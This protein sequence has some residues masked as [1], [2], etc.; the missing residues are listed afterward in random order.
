MGLSL[1]TLTA[2]QSQ[3]SSSKEEKGLTI[4]TSFYPVYAMTKL[5][6]G[7][8]NTVSMIQSGAG[9]HGFEPSANDVAKIYDADL[10][11]YHSQ[12][13]E[14]WAGDLDPS[15]QGS[16]V[17]VF[18][19]SSALSLEKVPGLEDMEVKAG[20]D[21]S[22]LYDPHTWTDPILV[23]QEAESIAKKLAEADSDHADSYYDNAA[24]LKVEAE[25]LTKTYQD[26]FASL[27]NKVFVTQHTAFSYLARRFGLEQ[28]GIAGVSSEQ[29]PT[30][31]Q[32]AQIQDF[33]KKY[34]V[35]TIFTEETVSPKTAQTVAQATGAEL[36]TLSPLESDPGNDQTYLENLAQN[37]ET[38]YQALK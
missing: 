4:V 30:S 9:I 16:D 5:V 29:E 23:A 28:L 32:L 17:A 10:F 33:V 11:I 38:L 24:A 18:E 21:A 6:S 14:S 19:A 37:L 8:L 25:A 1:L 13:L 27:T 3:S 34:Q 2:C 26:K 36:Q 7:D 35:K 20:M 12:I 22:S 15:L 31:K